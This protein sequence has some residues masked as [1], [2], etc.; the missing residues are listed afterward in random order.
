MERL[1]VTEAVTATLPVPAEPRPS[2][3][4]PLTAA[5]PSAPNTPSDATA[6][7]AQRP[8][9]LFFAGA[10]AGGGTLAA[11]GIKLCARLAGM[12]SW[13]ATG[14]DAGGG[15]L[16]GTYA[17]T[18]PEPAARLAAADARD[19]LELTGACTTGC[20]SSSV[21]TGGSAGALSISMGLLGGATL[22]SEGGGSGT[23]GSF[24]ALGVEGFAATGA[25][26]LPELGAEGS[27]GSFAAL[28]GGAARRLGGGVGSAGRGAESAGRDV[29]GASIGDCMATVGP[30]ST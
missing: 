26:C 21:Y 22:R 29:T 9:R 11:V 19:A 4:L 3:E 24:V 7:T 8:A 10:T 23:G 20:S 14:R 6:A 25:E 12:V 27:G 5:K 30:S 28:G 1:Q 16:G 2:A 17:R 13:G 18:G 15:A